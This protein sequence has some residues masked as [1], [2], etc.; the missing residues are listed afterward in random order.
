[1]TAAL[2]W[3]VSEPG[4]EHNLKYILSQFISHDLLPFV[5]V[6]VNGE[7]PQLRRTQTVCQGR[8]IYRFTFQDSESDKTYDEGFVH[9]VCHNL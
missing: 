8:N 3:P 5:V 1:M 7:G 2:N 4:G 9:F 6:V